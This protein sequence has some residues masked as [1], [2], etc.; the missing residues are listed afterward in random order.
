MIIVSGH[1]YVD[2]TARADYL[3]GCVPAIEAARALDDCIDF[4]LTA[5]PIDA[6]RINIY[7]AWESVE[8]VEEFRGSG[9]SGDQQDAIQ[10]AD[11]S[12]Y[13]IASSTS[14]T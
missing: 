10:R 7:E 5:D 9:P 14:L 4:H 2:E 8:A 3:A 13:E 6:S 12:Q 1:L 11:V